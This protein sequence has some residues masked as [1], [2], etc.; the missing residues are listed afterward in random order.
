[1]CRT[2]IGTMLESGI[3][4]AAI[5]SAGPVASAWSAEIQFQIAPPVLNPPS[6]PFSRLTCCLR[7]LGATPALR[8]PPIERM[9]E[10]PR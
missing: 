7:V 8:S 1:M 5:Q 10:I 9:L 3:Y 4:A 2:A 6:E